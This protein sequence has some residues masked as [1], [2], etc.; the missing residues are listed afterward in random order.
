MSKRNRKN[1]NNRNCG[2]EHEKMCCFKEQNNGIKTFY[3]SD[4]VGFVGNPKYIIGNGHSKITVTYKNGMFHASSLV[5]ELDEVFTLKELVEFIDDNL[6]CCYRI[7][8]NAIVWA[9]RR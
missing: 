6:E 4:C 1:N 5:N 3:E 2:C 8:Y 9:C 7:A